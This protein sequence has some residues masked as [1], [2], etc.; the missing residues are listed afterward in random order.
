[1][2]RGGTIGQIGL[3]NSIQSH[4]WKGM[5]WIDEMVRN[6]TV[7]NSRGGESIQNYKET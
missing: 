5:D 6:A 4:E 2:A 7:M 3:I 1:M